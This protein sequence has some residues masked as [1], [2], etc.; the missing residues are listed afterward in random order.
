MNT[1]LWVPKPVEDE[2][3]DEEHTEGGRSLQQQAS[4]NSVTSSR[5]RQTVR[6]GGGV[7]ES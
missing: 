6:R 5:S 2:M 1:F 3:S 4:G 7:R